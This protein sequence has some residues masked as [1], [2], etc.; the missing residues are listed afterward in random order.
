MFCRKAQILFTASLLFYCRFIFFFSRAISLLLC[1]C[2][3]LHACTLDVMVFSYDT[4]ECSKSKGIGGTLCA[5]P[6]EGHNLVVLCHQ[7]EFCLLV[8]L[9][10]YLCLNLYLYLCL[11]STHK[12][13]VFVDRVVNRKAWG[14]RFIVME[15]TRPWGGH[16]LLMFFTM[17]W[18]CENLYCMRFAGHM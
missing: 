8:Y 5:W 9:Y 17:F 13:N 11:Y 4:S 3:F 14:I 2:T 16:R 10:L 7:L 12:E 6:W 15:F 18:R 1:L